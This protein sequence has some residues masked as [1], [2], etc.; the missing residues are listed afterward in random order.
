MR[1][2]VLDSLGECL[3][4]LLKNQFG[5]RAVVGRGGTVI[6]E[7]RELFQSWLAL[8]GIFAP[9]VKSGTAICPC[10]A[11]TAGV[12]RTAA[13]ATVQ[14]VVLKWLL[15]IMSKRATGLEFKGTAGHASLLHF[16]DM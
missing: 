13:M 12:A 6:A 5:L 16:F 8:A 7:H 3:A 11:A 15:V 4:A 2:A 1:L 10:G 9:L 14:S